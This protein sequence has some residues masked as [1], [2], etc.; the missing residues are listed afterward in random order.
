MF[1]VKQLGSVG[2]KIFRLNEEKNIKRENYE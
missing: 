1:H 2:S